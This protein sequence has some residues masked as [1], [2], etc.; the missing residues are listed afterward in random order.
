V[1]WVPVAAVVLSVPA[2]ARA[3]DGVYHASPDPALTLQPRV[4]EVALHAGQGALHLPAS[5]WNGVW[6]VGGAWGPPAIDG[7]TP[8][9]LRLEMPVV[10]QRA[11]VATGSVLAAVGAGRTFAVLGPVAVGLSLDLG[12]VAPSF[13][14]A[15]VEALGYPFAERDTRA[16]Y[17]AS[18]TGTLRPLGLTAVVWTTPFVGANGELDWAAPGR[19]LTLRAGAGVGTDGQPRWFGGAGSRLS[20]DVEMGVSATVAGAPYGTLTELSVRWSLPTEAARS[21]PWD[22]ADAR[23][24][25]DED[26]RGRDVES[27]GVP[28]KT[29]VV[30]VGAE[31]CAPCRDARPML[32]RLA[33]R[34]DVAVRFVDAD[35]CPDFAQRHRVKAL[36]TFFVVDPHGMLLRRVLGF[37]PKILEGVLPP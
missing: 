28:G 17:G 24:L 22:G 37:D 15:A 11:G 1:R 32:E 13:G 6:T 26:V 16:Y 33:R 2:G 19:V 12:V 21:A 14:G 23:V 30:E 27:L 4:G 8:F 20:R 35:E 25:H 7:L 5:G 3:E 9:K 29:T 10:E 31:W 36:P 34:P 18:L